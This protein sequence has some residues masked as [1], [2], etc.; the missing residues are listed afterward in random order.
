MSILQQQHDCKRGERDMF[1]KAAM[2]DVSGHRHITLSRI[3]ALHD[4]RHPRRDKSNT[5][6]L[7]GVCSVVKIS[8]KKYWRPSIRKVYWTG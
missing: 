4:S 6:R 1:G 7:C 5:N 3:V 8:R 2:I